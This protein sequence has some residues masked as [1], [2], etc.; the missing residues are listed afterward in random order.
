[1]K[2]KNIYLCD[3]RRE[4]NI[5]IIA[6]ITIATA[7]IIGGVGI[8]HNTNKAIAPPLT[9]SVGCRE[10]HYPVINTL[11]GYKDELKRRHDK[12]ILADYISGV[13]R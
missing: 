11:K 1:M 9:L 8:V 4:L 10:C 3:K 7:T 12:D 5:A 6:A 2:R 13:D